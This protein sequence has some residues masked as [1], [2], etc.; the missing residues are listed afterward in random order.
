MAV[1]AGAVGS[2]RSL[3]FSPDGLTLASGEANGAILLWD[4]AGR[5]LAATLTGGGPINALAFT[6]DGKTL[7]SGDS[8]SRIVA[9]DLDTDEVIRRDC[10]TLAGDPGLRDAESLTPGVSYS[11]L[12]PA[13]VR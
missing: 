2:V 12:C 10:R 8:S 3:A 6:P 1:L 5:S 9:W 11:Q 7:M 13:R 4:V